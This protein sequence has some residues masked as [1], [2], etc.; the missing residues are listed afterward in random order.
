MNY[1]RLFIRDAFISGCLTIQFLAGFSLAEHYVCKFIIVKGP[2]MLPTI[3]A[4]NNIVLMDCFTPKFVRH[5]RKNEIILAANP[6][7]E[8]HTIVKRV[9]HLE[10]DYADFFDVPT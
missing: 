4:T 3:D 6:F 9:L 8:S 5:P 1:A 7:K 2:S 10:G